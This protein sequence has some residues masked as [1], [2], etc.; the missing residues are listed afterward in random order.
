MAVVVLAL[1]WGVDME[2]V[3]MLVQVVRM[4]SS[5]QTSHRQ[6][7]DR[8]QRKRLHRMIRHRMADLHQMKLHHRI[9]EYRQNY[10]LPYHCMV[11][12]LVR[13]L[14]NLQ[15][16][17]HMNLIQMEDRRQNYLIRYRIHRGQHH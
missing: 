7:V 12:R 14:L 4:D 6:M 1:A 15:W 2:L 13:S 10:R 16:V 3:V 17:H 9:V 11:M 8:R 5:H